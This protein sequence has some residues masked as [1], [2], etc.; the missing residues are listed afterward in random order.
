MLAVGNNTARARLSA[1]DV[2]NALAPRRRVRFVGGHAYGPSPR[3]KLDLYLPA[4]AADPAPLVVFFYGGGWE[5]GER[6]EYRFVGAALAARGV[7]V[8]LPDYRLHPEVRWDGFLA[9]GA[10]ALAWGRAHAAGFGLDPRRVLLMGHSAGA[11]IAAMLALDP[12][13][14]A[15]PL[16]GVIGLAGPYDFTPDTPARAAMF[17]PAPALAAAMPITYVS[18]TA[19]PMLL[20][21]GTKDTA[22]LPRNSDAL[23]ARLGAV[24]V[25]VALRHYRGIGHQL[26][27]GAIARPLRATAPVLADCLRFIADPA[28]AA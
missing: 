15:G 9:D 21:T 5:D 22:V 13:R 17:P 27:L 23:A 10:A 26:V 14:R 8:L 19:P 2:I 3:H 1:L 18:A 16:A 7:A 24:G 20:A 28:G 25:P 4:G 12:A 11:Y 6:R